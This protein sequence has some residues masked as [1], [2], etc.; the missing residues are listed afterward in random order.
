MS[1]S[2]AT[3]PAWRT[4]L[5]NAARTLGL[6][7]PF[8][9]L[10]E[11]R[12]AMT[13]P[14]P[15]EQGPD[16]LPLPDRLRMMRIGNTSDWR[17]FYEQGQKN[18]AAFFAFAREAG[19]DPAG[20][21][22]VLDWGCGCGR[23]ARHVGKHTPATVVGRD[24]DAFCVSWCEGRIPG[25][26]KSCSLTPPLD[27]ADS[28][29]DFAYGFSVIT[30]LPADD[31]RRWFAELGRVLKPGALLIVTFHDPGFGTGANAVFRAEADGVAV[32]EWTLPGSNLVAAFQDAETIARG[33]APSFDLV[34][35]VDSA[36]SPFIQAVAVLRRRAAGDTDMRTHVEM[37]AGERP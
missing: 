17:F 5:R 34:R 7:G 6:L 36:H 31:Q 11:V 28:S 9:R 29:I 3:R 15:P 1:S 32:T 2:A 12:R 4:G 10:D 8:Y 19:A 37:Q 30:H 24:I 21:E 35:H 14:R 27:L 18:A 20:F 16:G 23:I 33:A 22:R 26:Y 25:D 13:F